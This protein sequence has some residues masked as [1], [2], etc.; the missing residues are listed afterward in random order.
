MLIKLSNEDCNLF[1]NTPIGEWLDCLFDADG[2]EV[3]VELR[4]GLGETALEFA[5]RCFNVLV[6]SI[7]DE[8]EIEFI[9]IVDTTTAEAWGLDTF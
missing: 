4:R 6:E 3:L 5:S 7:F 1:Y 2:E 9:K 8:D